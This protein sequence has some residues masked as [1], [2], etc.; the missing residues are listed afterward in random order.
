MENPTESN[1]ELQLLL[2]NKLLLSQTKP[3]SIY[4]STHCRSMFLTGG[5]TE[6][7]VQFVCKSKEVTL[8]NM[9]ITG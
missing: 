3:V 6:A 8:T 9:D 1:G 2:V 4:F 7:A 5:E